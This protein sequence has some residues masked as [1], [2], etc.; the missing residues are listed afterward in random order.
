MASYDSAQIAGLIDI[1]IL[2]SLDRIVELKQEGLHRDDGLIFIQI[3][4]TQ[5]LRKYI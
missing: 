4:I 2:D 5:K 1:C 3:S